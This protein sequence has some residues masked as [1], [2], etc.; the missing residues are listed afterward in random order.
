M[1]L[2][3]RL[4]A[5]LSDTDIPEPKAP[6]PVLSPTVLNIGGGYFVLGPTQELMAEADRWNEIVRGTPKSRLTGIE[7]VQWH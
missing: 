6:E 5:W 1:N 3:Q 2:F 7:S 4:V